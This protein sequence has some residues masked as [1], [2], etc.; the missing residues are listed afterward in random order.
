MAAVREGG[1]GGTEWVGNRGRGRHSPAGGVKREGGG[2]T[3]RFNFFIVSDYFSEQ[4]SVITW[5]IGR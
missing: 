1:G 2:M 4:L 5:V 3:V